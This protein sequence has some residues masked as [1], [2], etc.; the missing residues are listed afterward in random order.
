M[1][2]GAKGTGSA[3]SKGKGGKV[4]KKV[5]V[6][7]FSIRSFWTTTT[8]DSPDA[9]MMSTYP[10]RQ[11]TTKPLLSHSPKTIDTSLL[12]FVPPSAQTIS[13]TTNSLQTHAV[14]NQRLPTRLG[15]NLR[16]RRL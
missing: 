9:T 2:S 13:H 7:V 4:T 6:V 3:G 14:H 16:R 11:A 15:Q 5:C 1:K 8:L 12:I 10:S